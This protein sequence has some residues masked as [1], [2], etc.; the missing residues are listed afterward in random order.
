MEDNGLGTQDK[1]IQAAV[2]LI[3]EKGFYCM[4]MKDIASAA[5]VS[6][7][8]VFRHFTNKRGILLAILHK[9]S[10]MPS[11]YEIFSNK[12][13]WD[14]AEDLMLISRTYQEAIRKKS[15][16]V[17]SLMQE[18]M[19]LSPEEKGKMPIFPFKDFMIRYFQKMQDRGKIDPQE[20][21]EA[22]AL[23]FIGLNFSYFFAWA[24]FQG[25]FTSI[26][27]EVYL[28]TC[29]DLFAKGLKRP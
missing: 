9:Y 25:D 14:I 11:M 2:T 16:L 27:Q 15:A 17:L 5:G 26:P 12:L 13:K 10:F 4:T 8:T 29:V 19:V 24:K 21:T 28:Q 7:M 1:I 22:L 20:N 6:E 23:A 3:L 18:S